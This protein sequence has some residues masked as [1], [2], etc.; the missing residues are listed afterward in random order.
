MTRDK[1]VERIAQA[2]YERARVYGQPLWCDLPESQRG[3]PRDLARAVIADIESAGLCIVPREPTEGMIKAA[4]RAK[5]PD[6][7]Y[8]LEAFAATYRAMIADRA[9]HQAGGGVDDRP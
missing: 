8:Y 1:L 4:M 5:T 7:G 3:H 2:I 9:P 6:A